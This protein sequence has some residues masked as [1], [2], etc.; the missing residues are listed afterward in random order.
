MD[1]YGSTVPS[2]EEKAKM[3]WSLGLLQA[4]PPNDINTDS[5][6]TIMLY[7]KCIAAHVFRKRSGNFIRKRSPQDRMPD[8]A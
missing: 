6:G 7:Y 3:R 4:V 2:E 8:P 1:V 5:E